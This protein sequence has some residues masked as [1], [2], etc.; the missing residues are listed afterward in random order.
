[1]APPGR[2]GGMRFSGAILNAT[3]SYDIPTRRVT[4]HAVSAPVRTSSL[5]GLGGPVN[6][7]AGECFVDELAELAGRY[8][9]A[10]RLS[11]IS[12][13]PARVVVGRVAGLAGWSGRGPAGSGQ[14]LGLDFCSER[15]R[16][17]DVAVAATAI[18]AE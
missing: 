13:P 12:A 18:A 6:T 8:P 2:V 3:P 4:E 17:A 10:Y 7:Y 5:R 11:I 1:M 14:G 15:G 9:L 16:G